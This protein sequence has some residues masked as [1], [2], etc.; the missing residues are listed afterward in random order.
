MAIRLANAD[1]Q[2][3]A[4]RFA[5]ALDAAG[6]PQRGVVVALLPNVPEFLFA[7]RGATWSGRT[8]VPVNWHLAD[9]DIEYI[10][11]DC[12]ADALL[13]HA[14]FESI[15]PACA[16]ASGAGVKM[17]VG[18]SLEGFGSFEDLDRFDDHELSEPLAGTI[19]LYTSGTTGRPKGVRPRDPGNERPPC[20]ASRMGSMMIETYLQ[21]S[22][23]GAHLIAAP[24]YHAAPSTYG[25]GA[26]LI[27]ADVVLME[28]WDAEEFLRI[29]EREQIIS[30]F[31]VPTHFVRLLQL[32][33][34]VRQKYDTSSLELV[35]HGAAPVAP[36][37]KR[38]MIEWWGPVLFEFYGGTEGGGVSIDSHTWLAH[39]GS[40][41]KPRPGLEVHILDADGASLPPGETGDIYFRSPEGSFEYKGDPEKTASAYRGDLYTLGDI[42]YVDDEGFLYLRDRKADTIIRGGVNIYPAQIE[43]ILIED[44][45]VRDCCVVGVPDEAYGEV[46]VAVIEMMEGA[47]AAPEL[48]ERLRARCAERLARDQQP[49]EY[50]IW[51]NLPRT[52]SGKLL[53]REVRDTLRASLDGVG[54]A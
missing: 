39:P 14:S 2:R 16:Q 45:D 25:E 15:A 33:E 47:D 10:V 37:I 27:G 13:V 48:I 34:D 23:S 46:V 24:L 22:A 35:C 36:D 8:F 54:S 40:V 53:R 52:E 32:P 20:F 38:R 49:V 17:S 42:G 19:M 18:G 5:R 12:G 4:H 6:V 51:P 43:A 30:T 44:D 21:D 28:R 31:L 1:I 3:R 11:G 7:L 26:A 50:A 41:G 9:P 29:V